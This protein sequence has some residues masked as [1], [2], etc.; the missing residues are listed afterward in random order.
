MCVCKIVRVLVSN[1]AR[2]CVC[3][4]LI[5]CDLDTSTLRRP[6]T[7]VDCSATENKN[8]YCR[9]I[10]CEASH[11]VLLSILCCFPTLSS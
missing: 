5:V 8:I 1:Y 7:D 4:C 9:V 3:V 11:F 2:V 6:G 10:I